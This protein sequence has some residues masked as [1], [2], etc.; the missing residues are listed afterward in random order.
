MQTNIYAQNAKGDLKLVAEIEGLDDP[1]LAVDMLLDEMPRLKQREF[2]VIDIDQIMIV[3]AGDEVIQPRRQ[4][5]VSNGNAPKPRRGRATVTTEPD[6]DE[7]EIEEG[8]EEPEAEAPKPTRG[9]AR[10]TKRTTTASAKSGGKKASP[11]R[12]NPKSAE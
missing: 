5:T 9:R 11:F 10:G 8:D 7:E 1:A 6:D 2:V 3:E 4:I 12:S